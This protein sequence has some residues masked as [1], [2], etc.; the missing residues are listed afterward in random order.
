[1]VFRC[2]VTNFVGLEKT[3]ESSDSK[4][5]YQVL[6]QLMISELLFNTIFIMMNATVTF[7]NNDTPWQQLLLKVTAAFILNFQMFSPDLKN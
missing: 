1:M 2:W 4:C 6:R 5:L 3:Y 7:N